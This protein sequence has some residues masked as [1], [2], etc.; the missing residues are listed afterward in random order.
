MS[1]LEGKWIPQIAGND[2]VLVAAVTS[3]SAVDVQYSGPVEGSKDMTGWLVE[4][5]QQQLAD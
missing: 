5:Y 1:W 2:G 4:G 3:E